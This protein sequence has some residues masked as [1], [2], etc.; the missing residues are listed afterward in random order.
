M[1]PG[2]AGLAYTVDPPQDGLNRSQPALSPSPLRLCDL[3]RG[4]PARSIRR[5]E[6]DE[7][8]EGRGQNSEVRHG[9]LTRDLP[10]R[11]ITSP[12]DLGSSPDGVPA[13]RV[14]PLADQK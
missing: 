10:N 4:R 2:R 14:R 8:A 1:S 5:G 9:E 7:R 13:H 6:D 11:S 3:C 12:C